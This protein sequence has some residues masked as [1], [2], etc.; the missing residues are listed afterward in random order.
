MKSRPQKGKQTSGQGGELEPS[1]GSIVPTAP[2]PA[3]CPHGPIVW[4]HVWGE[5]L[6][7][8]CGATVRR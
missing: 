2:A 1:E 8:D 4:T 3:E 6:C 7:L 5:L